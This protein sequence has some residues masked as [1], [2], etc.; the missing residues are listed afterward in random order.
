M[1]EN[2]RAAA[3]PINPKKGAV[4]SPLSAIFLC[5]FFFFFFLSNGKKGGTNAL[6]TKS[7][8]QES[9]CKQRKA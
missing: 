1:L 5:F 8:T 4:E 2:T 6:Q 9:A 3:A 7:S